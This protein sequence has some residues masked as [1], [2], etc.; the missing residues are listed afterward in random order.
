MSLVGGDE[1]S[2]I[3]SE[4]DAS[5]VVGGAP[6]NSI[7]AYRMAVSNVASIAVGSKH[8][9]GTY[10]D[11]GEAWCMGDNAR[12]QLGYLASEVDDQLKHPPTQVYVP[13]GVA[14]NIEGIVAA[15]EHS[16]AWF[17][18]AGGRRISCWGYPAY[19]GAIAGHSPPV[20]VKGTQRRM[21]VDSDEHGNYA[22][23]WQLEVNAASWLPTPGARSHISLSG[24]V[25]VKLGQVDSA[26]V[27]VDPQ[28]T[29]GEGD[30]IEPSLRG[31]RGLEFADTFISEQSLNFRLVDDRHSARLE[32][33]S[34]TSEAIAG[35]DGTCE[36]QRLFVRLSM[37]PSG[38]GR[39]PS[40]HSLW[41]SGASALPSETPPLGDQASE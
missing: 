40:E 16:C 4:H 8:L 7:E 37:A 5:I 32:P 14:L 41:V 22:C 28:Q 13:E 31:D 39:P 19:T 26:R 23:T 34:A 38:L 30:H 9:C 25:G 35:L 3:M 29:G 11:S 33:V 15:Q 20:S 1:L 27:R 21:L 6:Q 18:H 12:K 10:R 24:S 36:M 2:S 17:E